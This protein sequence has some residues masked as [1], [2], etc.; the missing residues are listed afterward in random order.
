MFVQLALQNGS[1]ECGEVERTFVAREKSGEVDKLQNHHSIVALRERQNPAEWRE[2]V[3]R[4]GR[5]VVVFGAG[6]AKFECVQNNK[7]V[8]PSFAKG[9]WAVRLALKG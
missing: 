6:D 3:R 8:E 1:V 5:R 7:I 4:A 9:E 2:T